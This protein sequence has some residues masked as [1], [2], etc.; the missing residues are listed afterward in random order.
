MYSCGIETYILAEL[1]YATVGLFN[2]NTAQYL[3]HAVSSSVAIDKA[4]ERYPLDLYTMT[5]K[6][7]LQLL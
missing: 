4:F 6:V 3:S 2:H 1:I 5:S 7:I